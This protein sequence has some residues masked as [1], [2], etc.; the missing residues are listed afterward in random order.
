MTAEQFLDNMSRAAD[1]SARLINEML[2]VGADADSLRPIIKRY[3]CVRFM[4]NPEE[5]DGEDI[6]KLAE[7]SVE[8]IANLQKNGLKVKEH[9]GTCA[10][11]SSAVTK[12]I[13]LLISLQKALNIKF[14]K[15]ETANI[16]TVSQL[17]VAVARELC[18]E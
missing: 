4:L 10:S 13:L 11:V 15:E 5:A 3:L 8:Q 18:K 9:S 1:E 7:Q 12:K 2:I 14:A 6:V 16:T 17:S